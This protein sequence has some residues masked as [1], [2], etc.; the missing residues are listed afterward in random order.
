[1]TLRR[2]RP[3]GPGALLLAFLAGALVLDA[4]PLSDEDIDR[5]AR[6]FAA[7]AAPIE[8]QARREGRPLS[9]RMLVIAR[10][11][12]LPDPEAPRVLVVD[13]IPFPHENAFLRDLG[14]R[15]GLIGPG[16]TGNAQIFGEMILSRESFAHA[17]PLV[18]HELM[19]VR[20]VQAAG[21]FE[22]FLR[23]YLR[24]VRT[25]GYRQAPYEVEA[26]AMN[27]RYDEPGEALAAP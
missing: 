6:E 8:A 21:G 27:E 20:Q 1:M 3:P 7:W 10:E 22:P 2:H 24:E 16:I 15:L 25:H 13:T 17:I 12:G 14:L 11:M 26:H 4:M 23:R 9:P 18:A 19:H 5:F